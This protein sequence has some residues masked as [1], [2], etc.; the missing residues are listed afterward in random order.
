M[1]YTNYHK[2]NHNVETCRVKRKEDS[3][4]AVSEVTTQQ[5]RVQKPMKYYYHYLWS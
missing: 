5:I 4:L 3:V 2:T 1:Y